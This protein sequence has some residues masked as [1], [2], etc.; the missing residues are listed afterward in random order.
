MMLLIVVLNLIYLG[1]LARMDWRT[2][3]VPRFATAIYV[4]CSFIYA[5]FY[6]PLFILHAIFICVLMYLILRNMKMGTG[7]RKIIFGLA[8]QLG[9]YF[10]IVLFAVMTIVLYVKEVSGKKVPI[11][12]VPVILCVYIAYVI[13]AA[14]TGNLE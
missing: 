11:P 9:G 8:L 5:I 3:T 2:H 7:D 12:M 13:Y 1:L 6:N 14:A 4:L 10:A